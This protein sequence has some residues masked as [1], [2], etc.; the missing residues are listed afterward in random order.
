MSRL[1]EEKVAEEAPR[2][3]QELPD[4]IMKNVQK[5]PRRKEQRE[6]SVEND[7]LPGLKKVVIDVLPSSPQLPPG[8]ISNN[9]A[10]DV[11]SLNV[12][13]M[14]LVRTE[15]LRDALECFEQ[16]VRLNPNNSK[17]WY[18]KG[19]SL[20]S[21]GESKEEALHCFQKAIEI[22]PLDAEAW[23]NKGAVL[24]MLGMERDALTCYERA[25]EIKPSYARAWQ[26]KGLLFLKLGNKKGAKEC[27]KNATQAGLK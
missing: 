24:A 20:V 16:A 9:D 5:R 3:E 25:T 8:Q 1:S 14:N 27:F 13:G 15:H 26:N 12:K 19:M 6:P 10:T 11:E 7:A 22:N 18:N 4:D 21:L 17:S 2:S 23:N